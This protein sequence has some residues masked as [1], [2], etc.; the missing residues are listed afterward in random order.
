MTLDAILQ[1][2]QQRVRQVVMSTLRV[3]QPEP[4]PEPRPY[5]HSRRCACGRATRW[6]RPRCR[7][8]ASLTRSI[9]RR[10]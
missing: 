10:A 2:Q 7:V 6:Q 9:R 8:C 3:Y 4:E 5:T 1:I